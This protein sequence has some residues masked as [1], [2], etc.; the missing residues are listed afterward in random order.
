MK[1]IICLS[2]FLCLLGPASSVT[3][4]DSSNAAI[5]K[6]ANMLNNLNHYPNSN[7]KNYLQSVIK[8]NKQTDS[9]RAIAKA[10]LNMQHN[11]SGSDRD[12]LDKFKNDPTLD[13]NSRALVKVLL[14]FSHMAS[15]S[16]KQILADIA[17][18]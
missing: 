6:M 5:S 16:E 4:A 7:E 11:I 15:S 2:L 12:T 10:I 1:A 3:L 13:N 8:D 9:V 17:G 14:G 18:K